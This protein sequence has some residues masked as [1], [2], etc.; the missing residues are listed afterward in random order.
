[1]VLLTPAAD[2]NIQR[3][4]HHASALPQPAENRA[5]L[6]VAGSAAAA[7]AVVVVA[8]TAVLVSRDSEPRMPESSAAGTAG[9]ERSDDR[10]DYGVRP[11]EHRA[12]RA[13]L[14]EWQSAQ[15]TGDG[16]GYAGLY[17]EPF[18]GAT[19]SGS[20]EKR[21]SSLEQWLD[22]RKSKVEATRPRVEIRDLEVRRDRQRLLADFTQRYFTERF[23]D[24][25]RK[26][27]EMLHSGGSLHIVRERMLS[28]TLVGP[29]QG[30]LADHTHIAMRWLVEQDIEAQRHELFVVV[31]TASW[32][33]RQIPVI[34]RD[35]ELARCRPVDGDAVHCRVFTGRFSA[36]D[37]GEVTFR[38]VR[39][40]S[41]LI[42]VRETFHRTGQQVADR[43]HWSLKLPTQ[44]TITPGFRTQ[45]TS[46]D[47]AMEAR[48]LAR[49]AKRFA[50]C[51][52]GVSL[53]AEAGTV[54]GEGGEEEPYA[55]VRCEKNGVLHGPSVMT[56]GA[57]YYVHQYRNGHRSKRYRIYGED[58]QLR[59]ECRDRSKLTECTYWREDGKVKAKFAE[60][61]LLECNGS[62]QQCEQIA[63]SLVIP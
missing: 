28:S 33:P 24:Y 40:S 41:D 60:Q 25:G 55:S 42:V 52:S 10:D 4:I 45:P 35:G 34:Q 61:E 2:S 48:Q 11:S 63:A 23:G 12:V 46:I 16:D 3:D 8:L 26:Q 15:L 31:A 37:I 9:A 62:R 1:M 14:A 30:D 54:E 59:A 56:D 38:L 50:R 22:D 5:V 57:D 19:R 7:L 18:T 21:F 51:G 20:R 27:I 32:G 6:V 17:A 13:L 49:L 47:A 44:V 58:R 29:L 36:T 53:S 39:E 43:V